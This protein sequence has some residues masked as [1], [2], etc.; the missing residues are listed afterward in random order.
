[1]RLSV[2]RNAANNGARPWPGNRANVLCAGLNVFKRVPVRP[3]AC[4]SQHKRKTANGH[5]LQGR[6]H[7]KLP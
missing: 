2:V 7:M 6:D 3:C 5:V 1:V 4:L